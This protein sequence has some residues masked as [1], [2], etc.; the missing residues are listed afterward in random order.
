MHKHFDEIGLE[1]IPGSTFASS[2]AGEAIFDFDEIDGWSCSL[3]RITSDG[4]ASA[5]LGLIRGGKSDMY[6][7]LFRMLEAQ[8]LQ[9]FEDE[10]WFQQPIREAERADCG[11]GHLQSE[12]I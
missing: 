8:L 5:E 10:D 1:L 4:G 11:Y 6:G 12:L 3:I 9:R 7:K 2:F